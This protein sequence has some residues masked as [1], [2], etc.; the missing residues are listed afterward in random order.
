ME[1]RNSA[2]AGK[3]S[4]VPHAVFLGLLRTNPGGRTSPG[5]PVLFYPPLADLLGLQ[6]TVG[7]AA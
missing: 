1:G 7:T 4:G 6:A 3:S 2:G 5:C